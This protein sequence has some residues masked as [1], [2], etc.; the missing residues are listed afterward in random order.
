VTNEYK[1]PRFNQ[2]RFAADQGWIVVS[3]DSRGSWNRGLEF[4][5]SLKGKMGTDVELADQIDGLLFLMRGYGK[6][7]S[8]VGGRDEIW[9]GLERGVCRTVDPD[10][11]VI[12][13]WSY[14]G[15]LVTQLVFITGIWR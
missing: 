3:I 7:D 2:A 13:G 14:G 11:V 6:M 10:R 5:G 1:Y 12:K 15:Y 9:K 4:E 8:E